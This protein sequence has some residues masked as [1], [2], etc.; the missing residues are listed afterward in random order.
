MHL[1]VIAVG[2]RLPAWV[3]RVFADYAERMPGPLRPE[4]IEL[5]PAGRGPPARRREIETQRLLRAVPAGARI[6]LLDEAGEQPSSAALAARLGAW[7]REGRDVALILGGADGVGEA[8]IRAAD[9]RLSLSRMTFP[10]AL[11]R[12]VL[13]EQ[14][15]RAWTITTGHPYHR[16]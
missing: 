12:V 5:A 16:E 3:N 15:Y 9:E 7:Q 1:R 2:R 8:L 14:L 10:H 4:L 11:A 6:V 13:A